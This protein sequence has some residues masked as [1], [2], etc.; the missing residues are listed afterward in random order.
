MSWDYYPHLAELPPR[1][2]CALLLDFHDIESAQEELEKWCSDKSAIGRSD[3]GAR[4]VYAALAE[5]GWRPAVQALARFFPLGPPLRWTRALHPVSDA[6]IQETV[7]WLL[8]AQRRLGGM[9]FPRGVAWEIL[10]RL[11]V[12]L[13]QERAWA[14]AWVAQGRELMRWHLRE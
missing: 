11:P 12:S 14:A 7:L 4:E 1:E 9:R 8:V 5:G 10:A 2:A 13:E 6:A 3:E